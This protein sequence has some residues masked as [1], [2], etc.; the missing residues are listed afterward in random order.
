LKPASILISDSSLF[1]SDIYIMCGIAGIIQSDPQ[2]FQKEH[3]A[4]MTGSLSHRGPDGEGLWQNDSQNVLLGHRRLSIIDLSDAA[5]QPMHYLQRYTIVHN[6]EIYNYIELRKELEKEGY[7]FQSRSDTEVILAAYDY[8]NEECVGRFEGMF[9]FAIW[10]EEE[11]ELFAARDRFGEKPFFYSFDGEN[12]FFGSEIKALWASGIEKRP[13]L[14]MLFNF[15]TIGYVDN[16]ADPE[17]TFYEN[18]FKLPPASSLFYSLELQELAIENYW[19]ID[20]VN[21]N[22]EITDDE[23]VEQFNSALKQSIKR[24]LR[25]DVVIGTSLSG[26][27][28]SSSIV[29]MISNLHSTNYNQQA[30]TAVFPG[31]EKDET[32]FA[33]KVVDQYHLDHATIELNAADFLKDWDQLCY[34]QEEPIGSASA[35]IQFKVFQVAKE[36]GVKVLLDGQGADE[37]L[38][39]YHK[40]YKWYWQ[41]LFLKRRLIRSGELKA[42]KQNGIQERFTFKNIIA[43]LFPDLASVVLERQYLLNALRQEDLTKEFVKLQSREAYYSTP[44]HFNLNGA[45]Y[46]NTRVHGLE[47]LLRYADRNSMAHGCEVR[48][49]FLDHTLVEFA[50]SLPSHFKIRKGWTKWLLRTA[51]NDSLPPD[52]SW[53]KEKIGFEPPQK[54]WMQN[55]GW[56]NAIH[57][58]R[59]KLVDSNILKKDILDKEITPMGS[60]E[61]LN[62][63]WRYL[64]A[65]Y[66]LK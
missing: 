19:D 59:R 57:A 58:A 3:L 27:I 13:N 66:L 23:A 51:M 60:H 7:T 56:Q 14:Q 52:I 20:L 64:A 31:F 62:Y 39:G 24:R 8:W 45:L 46:F 41:E 42:A 26:G 63:D 34:H 28:D 17:E 18:I 25:S 49:P 55:K 5:A 40:Y 21:R 29:G 36:K 11:K 61:G 12:L 43:S 47:E 54:L 30:F 50:F 53:R 10:D 33:K 37:I 6:G 4:R 2:L 15:L 9:A 38:A 32:S 16:P 22:T 1:I 35:Y 48:L 65:S 44:A